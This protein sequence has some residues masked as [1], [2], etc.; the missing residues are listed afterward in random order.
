MKTTI[1]APRIPLINSTTG[2][3]SHEWYLFFINVFEKIG[4]GDS[5]VTITKVDEVSS[6]NSLSPI[7][8]NL[9]GAGGPFDD[10]LPVLPSVGGLP[11]GLEPRVKNLEKTLIDMLLLPSKEEDGSLPYAVIGNSLNSTSISSTGHQIMHGDA[12]TWRDELGDALNLKSTGTGVAVNTSEN[13]IE[14]T[15][16]AQVA[17]DYLFTNT[18][19]N[20]DKDLAS[21]IYP[22]I[23]FLQANNNAPNFLLQYRWQVKGGAKV[24]SWSSILCNTLS[25]SYSSGTIHQVAHSAPIS[26]PVGTSLSDIVQFRICRDTDNDSGLFAGAD[27]YTGTVGVL[28]FDIHFMANSIGSTTEYIK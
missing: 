22:H 20:H 25:A 9:H 2:T 7:S 16:T 18:Q 12:R 8:E 14:F 1:P 5:T 27:P 4:G 3:M 10:L 13:V 6:F 19:L 17:T 15:A 28:S 24:T 23:H 21:A 11:I 26:V